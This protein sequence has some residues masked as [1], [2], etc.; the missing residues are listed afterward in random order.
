MKTKTVTSIAAMSVSAAILTIPVRVIAGDQQKPQN[1][2][3]L[4]TVVDLGTLRGSGV[5]A[6]SINERGW[7]VGA[8]NLSGDQNGHAFLWRDGKMADL[9]ALGGQNSFAG[10]IKTNRGLI[11]GAAETAS[12]D[13]LSED[14]CF[15]RSDQYSIHAANGLDLSG[16]RLARRR[17]DPPPNSRRRQRFRKLCQQSRRGGRM[18]GDKRF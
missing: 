2:P 10:V 8:A 14:F 12:P 3:V 7:A 1:R 17:E 15:L 16:I 18:G 13:P 9:G 11:P 6:S 5:T 4:Y